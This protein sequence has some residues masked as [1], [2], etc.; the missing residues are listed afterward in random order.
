M[1]QVKICGIT[2]VEDAEI[3][4]NFGADALGFNFVP[5]TP[6]FLEDQYAKQIM[7]SLSFFDEKIGVFA[8]EERN[9]V[10]K[11][12]SE[13]ELKTIQLHGNETPQDC[14][15]FVERGFRVIRAIRVKDSSTINH[16]SEYE[17][18][19]ILLDSFVKGKLGGTGKKFNWSL[20]KDFTA[21]KSIILSGGLNP[22]N[23]EEAL[24][25]VSPFGVDV[26]SGVERNNPRKKDSELVKK[27][28]VNAKSVLNIGQ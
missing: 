25:E 3:A 5:G 2:N 28:I 15:Y 17:N 12:S 20:V 6:R 26:C 13:L 8:D 16:V 24:K 21:R 27:F 19:I 1:V 9:K 7:S 14:N 22:S 23:V 4:I 11:I 10:E 18:C